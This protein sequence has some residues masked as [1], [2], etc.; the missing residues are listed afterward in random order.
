MASVQGANGFQLTTS[1][2]VLQACELPALAPG[3]DEV[4]I[5]VAGC[6]VCHTDIGFAFDGVPT[7]HALPLLLGH[8]ISG[9][10]VATGRE[11][12][13]LVRKPCDCSGC[14]SVRIMPSVHGGAAHDLSAAI[15]ARQ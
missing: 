5:E 7:R 4:V 15:Y 6:G 10:V 13:F 9:R 1:T 3:P 2:T 11:F 12:I 8:E 14:N